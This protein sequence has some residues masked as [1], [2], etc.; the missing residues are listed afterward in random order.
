MNHVFKMYRDAKGEHRWRL[1]ASNGRVV[2]DS[3]EGYKTR[4]GALHAAQKL[5]EKASGARI[6]KEGTQ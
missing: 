1:V 6:D 3:G 4:T 5:I 2:A